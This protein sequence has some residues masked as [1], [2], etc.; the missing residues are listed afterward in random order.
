MRFELPFNLPSLNEI[1]ALT[2]RRRGR[3]N[4]YNEEKKKL[5]S[6]IVTIVDK[7]LSEYEADSMEPPV[8]LVIK[9]V[10]GDKRSD[11]DNIAS[12][13]KFILDA[14]SKKE[15]WKLAS[16]DRVLENDGWKQI[17]GFRDSFETGDEPRVIIEFH[18]PLEEVLKEII[19]L[20]FD[21]GAIVSQTDNAI[22]NTPLEDADLKIDKALRL[23]TSLVPHGSSY[24][25]Y[26]ASI[27][28]KEKTLE[29]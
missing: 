28:R 4:P 26:L 1:I 24:F 5:E 13:K 12:G 14:L 25:N 21:A 9:W 3:Y 8:D 27:V 19:Q 23:L 7:Q 11:P 20:V 6:D 29:G 16:H 10:C 17:S 18:R 22:P 2:H 15:L